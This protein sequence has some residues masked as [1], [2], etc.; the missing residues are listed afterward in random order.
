[1]RVARRADQLLRRSATASAGAAAA[2]LAF[3]RRHRRRRRVRR[4]CAC[5][6]RPSE[7]GARK[8]RC[9]TAS[10]FHFLPPDARG[11]CLDACASALRSCCRSR[12][13]DVFHV[14]GLGFGREVLGLRALAPTRPDPPAGPCR[15]AA[16]VLAALR[17]GGARR[18]RRAGIVVLRACPGASRS[19]AP[20]LLPPHMEIF[21]IPEST[22]SF[23]PG[24]QR[25]C[26]SGDRVA[27]RPRRSLGRASRSQQRSSDG[28]RRRGAGSARL[29]RFAAVVL[30]WLRAAAAGR[31]GARIAATI[32]SCAT[33]FTC[34][35]AYRMSASSSSCA[36]R[37]CSCS[38]ATAK[39]A[40]S[41]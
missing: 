35:D 10:T 40:A 38:A 28:A 39:A 11:L 12:A 3:A 15:S 30:L 18:L 9:G 5:T 1:M 29:P 4:S 21:E 19:I 25:R 7:H 6:R 34:S 36:R 20:G 13:P 31:A 24:D 2:R 37:T 17:R 32:R 41:P 14:H 8:S 27:R 22:S 33:A 26:A 16:A 23:A